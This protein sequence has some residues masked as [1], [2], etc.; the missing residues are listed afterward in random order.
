[1]RPYP[2]EAS[3]TYTLGVRAREQYCS[4]A[5]HRAVG[6]ADCAE[7][8]RGDV[9]YHGPGQVVG[10]PSW[11]CGDDIGAVA[12]VRKLSTSCHQISA[13][14]HR[15]NACTAAQVSDIPREDP[16]IGVRISG[17]VS[18]HVALN[19]APDLRR[20][21]RSSPAGARRRA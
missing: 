3:A 9:T 13:R 19:V 15:V 21:E 5:G 7:R 1:M 18:T 4:G 11:T 12:Y 8:S 16:A 14:W 20:F 17:G 10:I 6:R 2:P